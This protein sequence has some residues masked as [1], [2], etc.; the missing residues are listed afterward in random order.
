[1]GAPPQGQAFRPTITVMP[2]PWNPNTR[3]VNIAIQGALPDVATRPPL[4]LV[5]LVD[6]SG[7]MEDANK[8]PL[9]KQSLGLM[10]GQLRAEDQVAIVAYAGSVGEVL[11]PTP[12]AP[13]PLAT[14]VRG[15]RRAPGTCRVPCNRL[16]MARENPPR[17]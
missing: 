14:M 7:S 1:M 8:L 16:R 9:L 4:N 13:R 11:P 2:T 10:L 5:F 12:A 17:L 6:T 3:L 15:V